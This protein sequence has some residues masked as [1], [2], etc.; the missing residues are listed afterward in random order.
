MRITTSSGATSGIER[1][2]TWWNDLSYDLDDLYPDALACLQ[3]VGALGLRV[4]I[5]GNQTAAM[6]RWARTAALP[7]DVISSSASLGVRKPDPRFF[8]RIVELAG[9]DPAE[10]AYVGD[11]VDND[12]LPAAAAG[13][14]AI[15]VRRGPV[16]Q[17][18]A[19]APGSRTRPRRPR[20]SSRGASL[21]HVSD[22]RIGLGIDA[23]AFDAD[24]P[25]VLGG[26]PIDH[27][28]GLAGHSDGDVIAHALTDALLGAAGLADIGALF[29]SDDERYRG[30]DSLELLTEAYRQV[31]E[32]GFELVNADC[33]LVG[34]E[35][36]IAPQ[37]GAMGERLAAALGVGVGPGGGACDDHRLPRVHRARRRARGAGGGAARAHFDVSHRF[38][39][40][41]ERPDLR[42]RCGFLR[43]A[44]PPFMLE[45]PISNERWHLL[46]ERFGGFQFWLVDEATDEILAEGNSLPARLDPAD[47]PDRGWEHVVEHA[48]SG[49]EEPTA[50]SAIQVLIDRKLHGGGLSALMLGEMR[51]LARGSR[52]HRSL[53]AGPAEPQEP[54]PA[55]ADREVRRLDDACRPALRPVAAGARAR[56]R[57]HSSG[58]AR[59]RC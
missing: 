57:P 18:G 17:P 22:L 45:S 30:A 34:Q 55:D 6:E 49:E 25:L 42:E 7:A 33:V 14:V 19:H 4:G 50:V 20:V 15:H 44:W 10:V 36:R 47:L 27:P 3:A 40:Y 21:D 24:V 5:V 58:S 26:V 29:P 43:E 9:C 23:H 51:R 52:V 12:V 2:T 35:P 16:G 13:L 28:R 11:R 37:R 1:P 38:F 48:T 46:Y 39:T 53:R 41:D 59:P 56:R 54:L 8:Q 31:R 32:A